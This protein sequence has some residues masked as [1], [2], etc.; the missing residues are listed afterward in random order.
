MADGIVASLA[1]PGGNI[2]GFT[3]GKYAIGGKKLEVLKEIARDVARVA[4]ILDP[5]QTSQIGVSRT[6]E[7]ALGRVGR[8]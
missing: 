5:G 2:T 3:T 7:V 1:Q 6:I 8:A 4:V